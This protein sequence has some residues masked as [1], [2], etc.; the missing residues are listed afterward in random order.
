MVVRLIVLIGLGIHVRN[1]E[2]LPSTGPAGMVA[3]SDA[4]INRV[5][6]E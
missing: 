3:F 5:A 2:R 6:F 1:R 4:G